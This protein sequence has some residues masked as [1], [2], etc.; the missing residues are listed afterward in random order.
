MTFLNDRFF[1]WFNQQLHPSQLLFTGLSAFVCGVILA[2]FFLWLFFQMRKNS[3][4]ERLTAIANLEKKSL[5]ERITARELIGDTLRQQCGQL[6]AEKV[7]L[8]KENRHIFEE[9]SSAR[10]RLEQLGHLRQEN[11]EQ[12]KLIRELQERDGEQRSANARL[13][14]R[15]EQEKLRSEE[16]LELL[17]QAR[18]QLR[19]QFA[20]LAQ[21][22]LEEKSTHFSK[23]S[24]EK[25]GNLLAPFHEQLSTFQKKADAIHLSET[26]DRAALQREIESLRTLNQQINEEAI[27]LTRA[28]KGDR[29]VQGS[30]GELVLERVLEQSA[31]RKGIEYETQS[32]FRDRKNRLQRPDVIV[33]LPEGRDVII[34]SKVSLSAWERYVNCDDEK[35]EATFLRSHVGAVRE[36][37]KLL[38]EKD[39]GSLNGVRSLDFVL[40]FMPVEAAFV[41]AFQADD[42]LF[43]EAVAKKIILVSPTTLLTTLRTIESIWRYE[44]QSRNTREIAERAAALYDKFCSFAED[45]ERMGKQLHT[46][47]TSYD[48]AMLRLTHG[49]GNLVSQVDRFPR[50]GVKVKKTIPGSIVER[51]DLQ[52]FPDQQNDGEK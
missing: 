27:N 39:Y 41:S 50:L 3:A 11:K 24:Q 30:W 13:Q 31:L 43:G 49:R 34:D 51:A 29:R 37:V 22:I 2:S 52:D 44:Q 19:L 26:K 47:Q 36:H 35:E 40:M 42:R 46:L 20:E 17:E 10:G 33:H 45:M 14:T 7:A 16:K 32:V 12:D 23:Q 48:S 15:I 6:A 5:S 4:L 38:G 18:E 1:S 9:L 21:S 8:E 25:I 28:L